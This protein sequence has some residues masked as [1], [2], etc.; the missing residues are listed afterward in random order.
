MTLL[1]T[2]GSRLSQLPALATSSRLASTP[3]APHSWMPGPLTCAAVGGLPGH[4]ARLEHRHGVLAATAGHGE[5]LPGVALGFQHLLELGHRVGLAAR[6]P[7]VQHFDL[8]GHAAG[9]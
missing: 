8:A 7:P 9:D 6:G 5:V 3:S 2:G 1:T 4:H